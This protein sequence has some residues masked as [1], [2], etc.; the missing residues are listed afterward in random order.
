MNR[1]LRTAP[2]KRC[3]ETSM[4]LRTLKREMLMRC[5]RESGCFFTKVLHTAGQSLGVEDQGQ[6]VAAAVP[7]AVPHRIGDLAQDGQPAAPRGELARKTIEI[8]RRKRGRVEH[9]RA[10]AQDDGDNCGYSFTIYTK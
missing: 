4:P 2:R 6:L 5:A 1:R 8:R 7:R 9:R 3:T 10:V